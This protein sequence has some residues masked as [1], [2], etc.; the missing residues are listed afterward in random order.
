MSSQEEQRRAA[1]RWLAGRT[2]EV[3][4]VDGGWWRREL[5]RRVSR[6]RLGQR[7]DW[8]R[9]PRLASPWQD[10]VAVERDGWRLRA[11]NLE[12]EDHVFSVEYRV[13]RRCRLGWVEQPWTPEPYRRCGLAS[14]G[15]VAL[16]R[17]YPGLSWHTLGGH[18][19]DSRGFWTAVGAGVPG[20]YQQREVCPH[21][22]SG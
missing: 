2:H 7:K 5:L 4:R 19:H 6:G 11:A 9:I 12:G 10:T 17:E 3:R 8:P 13:C 20:G 15:L 22:P 14:A 18:S 16:R 21:V 1:A